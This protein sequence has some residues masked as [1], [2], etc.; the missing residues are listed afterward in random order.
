MRTVPWDADCI[1]ARFP[2]INMLYPYRKMQHPH[3][4]PSQI[5]H[6]KVPQILAVRCID[7]LIDGISIPCPIA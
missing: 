7:S 3:G 1:N 2:D 6:F 5:S 4:I